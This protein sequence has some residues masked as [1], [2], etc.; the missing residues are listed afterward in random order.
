MQI[1]ITVGYSQDNLSMYPY[2]LKE[3]NGVS[4]ILEEV[5]N[6]LKAEEHEVIFI[7]NS[8]LE[9]KYNL[10]LILKQLLN[11]C[12]VVVYDNNTKGALCTFLLGIDKYNLN[13]CMTICSID[14]IIKFD[15]NDFLKDSKKNHYDASTVTFK[16]IHPKWSH[17]NIKDGLVV[18]ASGKKTISNV[19]STGIYYFNKGTELVEYAKR[20]IKKYNDHDN[21][22]V[23]YVL[24][25]YILDSKIV[26]AY[27]IDSSD[28]IFY[29]ENTNGM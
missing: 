27:G 11:K 16:S 14:Q 29:K 26:G 17:V 20:F 10:S 13:D 15:I 12:Q 9:K 18:E 22:Y 6:S 23:N 5:L 7:I 2:F 28:I 8:W 19:A 24:N 3:I 25:E 21:Y 4:T 1:V